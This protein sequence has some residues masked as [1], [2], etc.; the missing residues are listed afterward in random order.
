[1][2]KRIPAFAECL[3]CVENDCSATSTA[4]YIKVMSTR[5]DK[6]IARVDRA[7]AHLQSFC[8]ELNAFHQGSPFEVSVKQNPDGGYPIYYVS[9]VD[10][11]PHS[12][13]SI[14]GDIVHNL[15]SALDNTAYQLALDGNDGI[16]PTW[17]VYFPIAPTKS[18]F[19]ARRR[20]LLRRI[21]PTIETAVDSLEPWKDGKGHAIWQLAQISNRDK[22]EVP[23]EA[24]G[25]SRGVDIS[26][27]IMSSFGKM[28]GF[29][30]V[31]IPP[32]FLIPADKKCPLKVGDE[33]YIGPAEPE[34]ASKRQFR[35]DVTVH[36]PGV[37]AEAMPAIDIFRGMAA[38]VRQAVQDLSAYLH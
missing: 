33:L 28:S 26:V 18:D 1:M 19:E 29:K 16:T 17:K 14:A 27:D 20:G 7:D 23:L 10:P 11:I 37:V 38:T 13:A 6:L 36:A 22:H 31:Q 12:L 34:V 5:T 2:C 30:A 25:Y 3:R 21:G 8:G 9:R 35:F 15:R 4:A 32:L 24:A